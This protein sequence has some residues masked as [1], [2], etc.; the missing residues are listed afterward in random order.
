MSPLLSYI[1][2]RFLKGYA[3]RG[4][5]LRYVPDARLESEAESENEPDQAH[6]HLL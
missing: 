3:N 2:P 6:G 4:L 1:S 5:R